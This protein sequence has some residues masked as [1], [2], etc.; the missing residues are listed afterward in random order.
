MK[1]NNGMRNKLK[2]I[3]LFLLV[4]TVIFYITTLRNKSRK[5]ISD[6]EAKKKIMDIFND[7]HVEKLENRA[8]V[9]TKN[10]DYMIMVVGDEYILTDFAKYPPI[11]HHFKSNK[12]DIHVKILEIKK[13]GY[14]IEHDDHTHFVHMKIDPNKKLGDYIYIKD[15]HTYLDE[16]FENHKH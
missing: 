1:V 9:L 5:P 10:D 8:L 3:V 4:I 12:P 6:E 13:D 16:Y 15:P 7:N 11:V 14:L 2:I